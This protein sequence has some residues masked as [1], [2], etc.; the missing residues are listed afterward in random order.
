[1]NIESYKKAH[2]SLGLFNA[3][4]RFGRVAA[5][6]PDAIDLVHRMS[7]NDLLPLIGHTGYGAQTVLTTE[8][9]RIID[10]ITILSQRKDALLVTSGGRE[11]QVIEWLS[12]YVI[13]EDAKFEKKTNEISQLLLFGPKAMNFLQQFT[14]TS[15]IGLENFHFIEIEIN[16]I[17]VKLQKTNRIIESGWAVFDDKHKTNE[18]MVFLQ[19][20][21]EK[22]GG[23]V[24]DDPTYDLLR[25][26]A[27]IPIAPNELNEKHNPLE[28]TLVQAVSFTKGCY[29]G[30]EVIARLDTYDKVQRHLMGIEISEPFQN[31]SLPISISNSDGESIGEITSLA[32]SPSVN[33]SLGLAFIKTAFAIPEM[34]AK[35]GEGKITAKLVKLPFEV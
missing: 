34:N 15:L 16:G 4:A 5:I 13:M 35:I 23:T 26:E 25:I 28:T 17:T 30:Q 22:I 27:G 18:L 29:I 12:K 6:G 19:S 20:E 14:R 3:T 21:I 1:M 31:G 7:T 9:G 10:L 2:H 8:K 32:F 24:I 11:E 33:K